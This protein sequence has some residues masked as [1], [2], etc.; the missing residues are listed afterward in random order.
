MLTYLIHHYTVSPNIIEP[1][2]GKTLNISEGDNIT[3]R[4]TGYPPPDIVWLDNNGSEVNKTLV[5]RSNVSTAS[6]V[7]IVRGDSGVYTCLASNLVGDHNITVNVNVK[8]ELFTNTTLIHKK[9][10]GSVLCATPAVSI[11]HVPCMLTHI[12]VTSNVKVAASW[13]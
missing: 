8:C 11:E 6:S 9:M 4:A 12:Y 3:C 13:C 7:M 2:E 10:H 5:T 1:V